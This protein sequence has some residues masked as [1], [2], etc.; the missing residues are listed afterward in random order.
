MLRENTIFM[1]R[2]VQTSCVQ[3]WA[4]NKFPGSVPNTV[5]PTRGFIWFTLRAARVKAITILITKDIN[6]QKIQFWFS[7]KYKK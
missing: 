2:N 1:S 6:G 7:P 4:H 3:H 5:Q